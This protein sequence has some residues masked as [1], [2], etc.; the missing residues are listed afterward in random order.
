MYMC[1][2]DS[3]NSRNKWR[4]LVNT[5]MNFGFHESRGYFLS[6]W[7]PI[8]FSRR[9][10]LTELLKNAALS[11]ELFRRN[12]KFTWRGAHFNS[13]VV[14]LCHAQLW[15]CVIWFPL[16]RMIMTELP[17]NDVALTHQ[18][19]RAWLSQRS[20]ELSLKVYYTRKK[21]L[22]SLKNS[23]LET[24]FILCCQIT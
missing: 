12:T 13:H 2:L 21:N 16:H 3:H 22:R 6:S 4:A 17:W 15:L 1:R 7:A 23:K 19:I 9:F 8:S 14:S 20:F 10:L 5:D 11:P 24:R 18:D